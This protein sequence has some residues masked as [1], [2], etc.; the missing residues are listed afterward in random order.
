[1]TDKPAADIQSLYPFLYSGSSDVDDVLEQ[2]RRST[3]AK[4]R[5][6]TE[7]R[8]TVVAR[9]GAR[10]VECAAAMAGRFRAGGRLLTFGNGGSSTEAQ[11]LASLFLSPAGE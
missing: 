5:E 7:L 4:A 6:I 8:A 2:V 3:L 9:D 10:L 1:M 11:D